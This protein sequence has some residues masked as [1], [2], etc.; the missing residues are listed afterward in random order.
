MVDQVDQAPE[1]TGGEQRPSPPL[2]SQLRPAGAGALGVAPA[3]VDAYRAGAALPA[4][5]GGAARARWSRS[6]ASTRCGRS[7]SPQQHPTLAPWY[8]RLS[9]FE[10]YSSPWFAAIYLLLFVSLVGCVLPRSRAH[11]T[12]V[13]AR[14]PAA[15]RN[16]TRLPVHRVVVDRRSHRPTSW[17]APRRVLRARPVPGRRRRRVGRPPSAGHWRETGNLV[18]HL[19]LLLLLVAVA[20][21]SLFGFKANVLVVEGGGFANTVTAYD[22]FAGGAAFDDELAA[23]RSRFTLDDL[24]VRY[25]Q[26]AT[27]A[28]RRATSAPR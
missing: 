8:E 26:A 7:S 27:S 5:A 11:W 9:L 13:R 3:H 4:D 12:A 25:Q 22:T 16:L 19:A 14:P 10:V 23:R 1:R 17:P 20:L 2:P 24:A 21:G 15:P 28:A 18:F 6:A